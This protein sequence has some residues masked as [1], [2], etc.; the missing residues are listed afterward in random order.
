MNEYEVTVWDGGDFIGFTSWK[1]VSVKATRCAVSEDGELYLFNKD[2]DSVAV[3]A[4]DTWQSVI[5]V[6][7]EKGC[8]CE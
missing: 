1:K 3:F 7:Q 4:R 8:C 5:L 6:D 2:G